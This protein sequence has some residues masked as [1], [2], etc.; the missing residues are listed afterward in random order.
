MHRPATTLVLFLLLVPD[1]R[2]PAL[3]G[4]DLEGVRGDVRGNVLAHLALDSLPC[5]A[6]AWRVERLERDSP[7]AVREALEAYG[8][9]APEVNIESWRAKDCWKATIRVIPGP[10]VLWRKVDV[11]VEGEGA[12]DPEFVGLLR[13]NPLRPGQ[14]LEHAPYEDF[15]KKLLDLARRRGYFSAA[16]EARQIDVFPDELAADATL[17]LVTGP[18]FRFGPITFDQAVLRQG[19]VERYVD[20]KPGQPYD[21]EK[22]SDFY[23]ALLGSGYFGGV[24]VR[25]VPGTPPD[26]DVPIAVRLTAGKRQVYTAG[27]GYSTDTGPRVR[28]GYTNRRL[29]DSGHQFEVRANISPR[30]QEAGVSYR[31]PWANPREEWLNFDVAYKNEQTSSEKTESIKTGVKLFKRLPGDL[32]GTVFLDVGQERST[33]ADVTD[34]VFLVVP[35]VSLSHTERSNI[36]R[37]LHG[38]RLTLTLS[39]T[40]QAFGS[41]ARFIQAELQGKLILPAW[42]TA[43]VLL[44]AEAGVTAKDQFDRLPASVRYFAGGDTS[45]RGYAYESLGPVD[46]N[47]KVLG[48]S[49]KLVASVEFDQK[50]LENWSFAAF[51]DAGNAFDTFT[52]LDLKAGVG[53]GI[54]WYS[55]LG[56]IRFDVA[57]PLAKDAPDSWRIH[58]TLGP[59]L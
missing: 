39:G 11:R 2:H 24:D 58:V 53:G 4:L 20:F 18:R 49:H 16:L 41:D 31:I 22:V 15:K 14:P 35:G 45:V 8:Y 26:L 42:P 30:L 13:T 52:N 3:A 51:I 55:P 44:R 9:Y 57:V 37:P 48:G 46:A 50:V 23:N 7:R 47:G 6:P 33:I 29:N 28:G 12:T 54:R 36:P 32:I 38:H 59:D 17:V 25:P 43:R 27:L 56:P 34:N 1:P 21:G 10:R 40:T 5:D 19:L